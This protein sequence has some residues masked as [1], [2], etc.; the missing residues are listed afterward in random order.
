MMKRFPVTFQGARGVQTLDVMAAESMLERMRGLLARP[1]LQRGEGML[2][3]S[4]NLV[5][6]FGMRYPIDV[7]FIQRDG[8]VLKVTDALV[9]RRASG[10]VRADCVLELAAG[11]ARRCGI[12]P[13]LRLP[14][15]KRQNGE[16][17]HG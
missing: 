1:T 11:E 16:R 9:P 17:G 13:G 14:L 8:V 7:V 5:H 15:A 10:H 6:T 4:C 12:A 2:L 3:H